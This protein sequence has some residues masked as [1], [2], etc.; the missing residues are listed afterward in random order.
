MD[1]DT[2]STRD[3]L[4]AA[5]LLASGAKIDHLEWQDRNAWFIFKDRDSCSFAYKRYLNREMNVIAKD[6]ADAIRTI[7]GLLRA[8]G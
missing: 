7:K 8:G 1:N 4:T 2:Y 3:Y 6:Y 5:A